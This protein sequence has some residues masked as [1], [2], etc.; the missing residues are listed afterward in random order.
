[1][2]SGLIDVSILL[3]WG[4]RSF[5]PTAASR[6]AAAIVTTV[7]VAG[8]SLYILLGTIVPAYAPPGVYNRAAPVRPQETEI[9]ARFGDG[10]ELV[11]YQLWPQTV[12]PGHAVC[13]TAVWRCL[14]PVEK[15]YT[16]GLQILG[17]N[18]EVYGERYFY[19]GHGGFPTGMWKPGDTFRE[20]YWIPPTRPGPLPPLGRVQISFFLD[21]GVGKWTPLPLTDASGKPIGGSSIPGRLKLA[22]ESPVGTGAK[23]EHQAK[24]KV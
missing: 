2:L 19:P 24:N 17:R 9:H 15:N 23:P 18:M 16:L 21:E 10:I 3:A 11:S 5:L 8:V 14:K 7:V 22:A 1:M 4:W 12:K 13:V 6:R 20:V